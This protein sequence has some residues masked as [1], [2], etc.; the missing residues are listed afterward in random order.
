MDSGSYE[1]ERREKWASSGGIIKAR[2]KQSIG[3]ERQLGLEPIALRLAAEMSWSGGLNNNFVSTHELLGNLALL[4]VS[5]LCCCYCSASTSRHPSHPRL[6]HHYSPAFSSSLCR[7]ERRGSGS[8][9]QPSKHWQSSG[10]ERN[11]L[12]VY[13][14]FSPGSCKLEGSQQ[15]KGEHLQN[16]ARSRVLR[17][18]ETLA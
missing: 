2:K 5:V 3:M 14:R 15:R 10:G 17:S 12:G 11:D 18:W 1:E 7:R 6:Q 13:S 4:R 16:K 8:L 9:Q